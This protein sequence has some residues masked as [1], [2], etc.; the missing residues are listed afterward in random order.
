[1][2][3]ELRTDGDPIAWPA[4]STAQNQ[5]WQLRQ[6]APPLEFP[7][8]LTCMPREEEQVLSPQF[9]RNQQDA[10]MRWGGERRGSKLKTVPWLCNYTQHWPV[11]YI[12]G[13][14]ISQCLAFV[15]GYT[16]FGHFVLATSPSIGVHPSCSSTSAS[17]RWW[18]HKPN[19]SCKQGFPCVLAIALNEDMRNPWTK[20]LVLPARDSAFWSKVSGHWHH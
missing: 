5:L 4:W 15:G 16:I 6:P 17:F 14:M 9:T 8:V 18:V 12:G 10:S 19:Y 7:G 1:M 11:C 20:K 2:K 3:D 13:M